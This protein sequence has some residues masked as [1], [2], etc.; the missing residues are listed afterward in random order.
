[1]TARRVFEARQCAPYERKI[2]SNFKRINEKPMHE[3]VLEHLKS[4]KSITNVEAQALWR[5]RALPKRINELR[6]AGHSILAERR[7]DSTGQHY[8]RYSMPSAA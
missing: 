6:A 8:V 7:T 4:G 2:V 3:L 1:V 5:C